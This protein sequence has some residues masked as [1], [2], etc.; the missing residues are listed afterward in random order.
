MPRLRQPNLRA[1]QLAAPLQQL[2]QALRRRTARRI[3]MQLFMFTRHVPRNHFRI[4]PIRL[5]ASTHT[6]GVLLH[7]ARIEHI[8]RHSRRVR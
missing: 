6:F 8:H 4:E 1:H 7:I 2:L 5:A 3:G